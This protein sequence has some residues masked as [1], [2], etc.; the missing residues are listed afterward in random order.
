M[1][2]VPLFRTWGK[3]REN[4]PGTQ[5]ESRIMDLTQYKKPPFGGILKVQR[6]QVEF[7]PPGELY[8][9]SESFEECF[10][11]GEDGFLLGGS[12]FTEAGHGRQDRGHL[13]S[14]FADG[15]VPE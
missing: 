1:H 11:P 3:K 14:I 4:A 5:T 13:C 2:A 8:N 9:I 15:S 7:L 10:E 6:G 12:V